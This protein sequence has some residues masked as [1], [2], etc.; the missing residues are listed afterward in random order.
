MNS[1][2]IRVGRACDS[3]FNWDDSAHLFSIHS[4]L[5]GLRQNDALPENSKWRAAERLL[6]LI[7]QYLNPPLSAQRL[8]LPTQIGHPRLVSLAQ[9]TQCPLT[10]GIRH[11][12]PIMNATQCAVFVDLLCGDNRMS[13]YHGCHGIAPRMPH[14][15]TWVLAH[16]AQFYYRPPRLIQRSKC[17]CRRKGRRW[18]QS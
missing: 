7:M 12:V 8:F 5:T 4:I 2:Y 9:Y 11:F 16:P 13:Q 15:P 18:S 14:S 6:C 10:L 1:F 3:Y 17:D